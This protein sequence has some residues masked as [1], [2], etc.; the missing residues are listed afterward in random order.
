MCEIED[1]VRAQDVR[2]HVN[3]ITPYNTL[4]ISG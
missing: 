2:V 4:Q 3:V 1:G